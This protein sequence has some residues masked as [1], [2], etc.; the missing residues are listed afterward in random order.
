MCGVCK[1]IE[2]HM[3]FIFWIEMQMDKVFEEGELTES[4]SLK[5]ENHL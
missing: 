5:C 4:V 1:D 2:K 3:L